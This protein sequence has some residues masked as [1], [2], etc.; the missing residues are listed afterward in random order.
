MLN[1]HFL[2]L[3]DR[4][5]MSRHVVRKTNF[6]M[7]CQLQETDL[8][9]NGRG[10]LIL[11]SSKGKVNSDVDSLNLPFFD[12]EY[13][14]T[15]RETGHVE[16][17]GACPGLRPDGENEFTIA[18]RLPP[19]WQ[20]FPKEQLLNLFRAC[21]MDVQRR[22]QGGGGQGW[23]PDLHKD[24]QVLSCLAKLLLRFHMVWRVIME[25]A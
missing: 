19:G 17:I 14:N 18:S 16:L 25:I 5:I 6:S 9:R 12:I 13:Y 23:H 11:C 20:Q 4:V 1:V 10:A 8:R 22:L 7:A 15:F 24:P 21:P 2:A 3:C